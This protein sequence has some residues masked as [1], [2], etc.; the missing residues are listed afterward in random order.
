MSSKPSSL[1]SLRI[2]AIPRSSKLDLGPRKVVDTDYETVTPPVSP[3]VDDSKHALGEVSSS[4]VTAMIRMGGHSGKGKG[5]GRNALKGDGTTFSLLSQTIPHMKFRFPD[6][7][8]YKFVQTYELLA[9]MTQSNSSF[10]SFGLALTSNQINQFSSFAAIFDQYKVTEIEVW[11]LP[12]HTNPLSVASAANVGLL[13]S[14]IDYDNTG[15]TATALACEQYSNCVVSPSYQ[16]HYRKFRPHIAIA[17]YAGSFSGY[18]NEP[19]GWV[20]TSTS[21]T[22]MYAIAGG[23]SPS[24]ATTDEQVYD[25]ILRLHVE[26]RNTK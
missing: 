1:P 14:V 24:D 15:S 2:V 21:T 4:V 19:M 26:F 25:F 13:Y 8:P 20:D 16:G 6:N 11:I 10:T 7:V 18:S 5:K 9:Y 23:V 17:N 12:R 3:V 22:Q